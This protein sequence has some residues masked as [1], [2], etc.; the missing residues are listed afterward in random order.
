MIAEDAL[1]GREHGLYVYVDELERFMEQSTAIKKKTTTRDMTTGN[2]AKEIML[3]A[4]P[5]MFGNIF[6]MLY[7]Q[8][9]T[10]EIAD[11]LGV[12]WSTAKDAVK[13]VRQLAQE[14]TGLTRN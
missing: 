7:N 6:Q 3:F 9:G 1:Y 10:Q 14:H 2:I 5:L 8:C 11:E 12:A 13:K 4:L